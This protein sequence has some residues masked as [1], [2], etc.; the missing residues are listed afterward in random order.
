MQQ[1]CISPP[2][3]PPELP[4]VVAHEEEVL[5]RSSVVLSQA[6]NQCGSLP[7]TR[8]P[9]NPPTPILPS[10]APAPHRPLVPAASPPGPSSAS[11]ATPESSGHRCPEV[12]G[13]SCAHMTGSGTPLSL[14]VLECVSGRL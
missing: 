8:R 12:L 4:R 13:D 10:F 9:G 1:A 3:E 5:G 2:A 6:V 14:C 11:Q 7:C